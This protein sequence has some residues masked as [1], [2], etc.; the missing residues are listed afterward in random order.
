MGRDLMALRALRQAMIFSVG[1][2][3]SYSCKSRLAINI[4]AAK[5]AKKIPTASKLTGR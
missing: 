5:T 2:A 3:A 1:I 4:Q